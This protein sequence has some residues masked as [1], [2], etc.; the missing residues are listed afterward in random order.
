MNFMTARFERIVSWAVL[1]PLIAPLI[2]GRRLLYPFVFH[3]TSF[4]Y[5]AVAGLAAWFLLARRKFSSVRRDRILLSLVVFLGV[6]ALSDVASGGFFFGLFGNYERMMGLALWAAL[7]IFILLLSVVLATDALWQRC[8]RTASVVAGAV[9]FYGLLQYYRIAFVI[10]AVDERM[11]STL[12][13]PAFLGGYLLVSVGLALLAA[14]R[15]RSL[16]WRRALLAIAALCAW[17]VVLTATRGAIAGLIAG[18]IA[19]SIAFLW[20]KRGAFSRGKRLVVVGALGGVFIFSLAGFLGRSEFSKSSF[21]PLRRLATISISDFSVRSRLLLWRVGMRSFRERPILG[22]GENRA[23]LGIDRFFLP[24]IHE[25]WVDS[26]HNAWLDLM[27]AHGLVGVTAMGWMIFEICRAILAYRVRDPAGAAVFLGVFVGYGVQALAIFDTLPV[28]LS[29]SVLIGFLRFASRPPGTAAFEAQAPPRFVSVMLAVALIAFF[30]VTVLRSARAL[31]A[32]SDGYRLARRGAPVAEF[33]PRFGEAR[34][35]ALLGHANIAMLMRDAALAVILRLDRPSGSEFAP[36][37]S[38]IEEAYAAAREREADT[39]QTYT[40][41]ARLYA[42][43]PPDYSGLAPREHV[44]E[45]FRLARERSP[46]RSD[47]AADEAM[48]LRA[49]AAGDN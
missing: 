21:V 46:G 20:Q 17:G 13:N 4:F 16:V 3:R 14:S 5:L 39:S 30:G 31:S 12:G 34:A 11:F 43:L 32:A 37:L 45:L 24:G 23:V 15:E 35:L 8:L 47:L 29:L 9:S 19:G 27:L 18:L 7:F 22:W 49:A 10:R 42:A 2:V 48:Y 33:L 6:K 1:L 36:L 44:A 25:S 28:L 26:A 38:D 40:D 41:L